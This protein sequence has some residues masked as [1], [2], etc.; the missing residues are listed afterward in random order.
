MAAPEEEAGWREEDPLVEQVGSFLQEEKNHFV[1]IYTGKNPQSSSPQE[2]KSQPQ[3]KRK[4]ER[5]FAVI[6]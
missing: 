4:G 5:G 3:K 2:S 6:S 1:Y